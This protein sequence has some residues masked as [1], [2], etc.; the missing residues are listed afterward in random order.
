[1]GTANLPR[2]ARRIGRSGTVWQDGQKLGEV[3]QIELTVELEQIAVPIPGSF[4]DGVIPGGHSLRGTFRHQDLHDRWALMILD[5]IAARI[6][7]DPSTAVLPVFSL[8]TKLAQVGLP[9]TRY[10]LYDCEIFQ[11]E[12]GFGME[13][14]LL[15]RDVPFSCD[16]AVLLEG[17]VYS[18]NGQIQI[19]TRQ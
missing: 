7:G 1:M 10:G 5:F 16:R 19:V 2:H 4:Q 6:S 8:T 13:E 3:V 14:D 9:I 18:P 12:L 15:V 17:F 11:A